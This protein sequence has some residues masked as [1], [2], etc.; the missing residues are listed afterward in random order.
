MKS[1][2]PFLLIVISIGLYFMH[3]A[4]RYSEVQNLRAQVA[5]YNDA[6]TRAKDLE[7]KR[8]ELLT[9]YNTFSPDNLDRIEKLV[10]DTVNSVKLVSDINNVAGKYGIIIKSISTLDQPIDNSQSVA[11]GGTPVKPYVTTVV[12]FKFSASYQNLVLFLKDLEKS[13]QLIDIKSIGFDVPTDVA[14][15]GVY[16]YQVSFQTYSLK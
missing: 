15:K 10:P 7:K 3:I 6:L 13:L 16:G 11:T 4:P 2:T 8:D 12:A 1:L 5:Q 14:S 9:T